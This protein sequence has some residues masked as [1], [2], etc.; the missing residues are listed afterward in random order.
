M[1]MFGRLELI[2]R[3]E[4]CALNRTATREQPN[5]AESML[6]TS[7]MSFLFRKTDHMIEL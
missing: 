2:E 6:H 1:T 7:K 3:Q 5:V 4:I